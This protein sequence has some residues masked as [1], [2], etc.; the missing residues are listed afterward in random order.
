MLLN[1]IYSFE[2]QHLD[3]IEIDIEVHRISLNLCE[4]VN[5]VT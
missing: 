2:R 5:L 1:I 3:S 4:S